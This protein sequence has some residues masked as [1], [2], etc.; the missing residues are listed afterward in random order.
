VNVLA[1]LEVRVIFEL[2]PLQIAVAVAGLVTT[3]EGL[4]V[5]V[6]KVV[7]PV[8]PPLEVGVTV[9]VTIAGVVLLA[10]T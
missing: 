3:G 6:T 1:T 4:T 7:P 2:V 8:Q 10:L 5:T 9:N